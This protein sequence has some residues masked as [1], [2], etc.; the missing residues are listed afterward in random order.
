MGFA[1]S[2]LLTRAVSEWEW[3]NTAALMRREVELGGLQGFFTEPPGPATLAR[4]NDRISRLFTGLPE[5]VRVKIWDRLGTGI[6][7]DGTQVVG[8]RL[9]DNYELKEAREGEV[10]VEIQTLDKAEQRY[11]RPGF[12][13]LAEVYVPILASGTR[14]VLGVIEV[15]KAPERLF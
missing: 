11:E 13:T 5:V 3:E 4:W 1:L 10:A 8:Q 6:L 2:H 9:P 7:P 12:S 15:Y 14:D